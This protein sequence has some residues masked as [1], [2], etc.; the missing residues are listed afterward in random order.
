MAKSKST[1]GQTTIYKRKWINALKALHL[2]STFS[3]LSLDQYL[4]W[5]TICYYGYLPPCN[6]CLDIG[7]VHYLYVWSRLI[8]ICG[9][10]HFKLTYAWRRGTFVFINNYFIWEL[11]GTIIHINNEQSQCLST[12]Y[13][14]IW[15]MYL[16]VDTLLQS[17]GSYQDFLEIGLLLITK[18]L[19]QRFLFVNLKS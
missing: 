4:C 2:I 13:T 5:W 18:L 7:I 11:Y 12:D 1:K 15:S 3:S 16:S 14:C 6:Q 9:I 8:C 10:L 19:N 17:V